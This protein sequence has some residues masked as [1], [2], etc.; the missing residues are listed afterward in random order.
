MVQGT[1]IQRRRFIVLI[2]IIGA[3]SGSTFQVNS[4][5][6]DVTVV[7]LQ[8]IQVANS[9]TAFKADQINV[10]ISIT[11]VYFQDIL[12]VSMTVTIPSEVEFLNSSATDL[13]IEKDAEKF[14]YTLGTLQVEKK[15]IFSIT[16]NV[17][18]SESISITLQPVNVSFQLLNGISGYE[19]SN[20]EEIL[21]KGERIVTTTQSLLPIPKGKTPANPILPI[22]GYLLPLIVFSLSVVVLRRRKH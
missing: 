14:D 11:N 19:L 17:T 3:I 16:Y 10:S 1:R 4:H 2:L 12:N 6:S 21:L 5:P 7:P 20:S 15:A 9:L 13:E 18:S 8:L 22:I